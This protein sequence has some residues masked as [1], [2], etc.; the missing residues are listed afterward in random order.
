MARI[1]RVIAPAGHGRSAVIRLLRHY[2]AM[3]G[4]GVG[5]ARLSRLV[6]FG[7]SLCLRPTGTVALSSVFQLTEAVLKR[8]LVAETRDARRLSDD[9]RTILRLLENPVAIVPGTAMADIPPGLPGAL[10]SA[11]LSVRRLCGDV[12]PSRAQDGMAAWSRPSF[13]QPVAS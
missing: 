6:A 4:K 2:C 9:E 10:A 12:I 5:G 13:V 8:H 1:E 11:V 3:R 7:Q